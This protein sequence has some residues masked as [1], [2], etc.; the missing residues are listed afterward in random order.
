MEAYNAIEMLEAKC[1]ELCDNFPLCERIFINQKTAF[2]K[3]VITPAFNGTIFYCCEK[4][5]D[6]SSY[7]EF[8][9]V[10]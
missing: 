4:T 9:P 6:D 1:R 3:K 10:R 5:K 7:L 8:I 2:R